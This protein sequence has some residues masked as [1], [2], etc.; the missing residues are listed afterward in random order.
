[1]II[2]GLRHSEQ[3]FN[4]RSTGVSSALLFISVG[5]KC[6]NTD[7]EK[8]KKTSKTVNKTLDCW[9]FCYKNSAFNQKY[10]NLEE[11]IKVI[12]VNNVNIKNICSS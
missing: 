1:M 12:S 3:T 11:V 5:G 8:S 10:K 9:T 4:S 6:T 2:G 7:T